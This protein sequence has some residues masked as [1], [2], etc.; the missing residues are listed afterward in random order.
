MLPERLWQIFPGYFQYEARGMEK[1][2]TST[3]GAE[4]QTLPAP[5]GAENRAARK[6]MEAGSGGTG[7]KAGG[8]SKSKA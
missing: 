5:T 6:L 8:G 4:L 3:K 7:C 2:G 1:V